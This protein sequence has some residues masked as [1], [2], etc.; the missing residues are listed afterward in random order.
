M[1]YCDG[2]YGMRRSFGRMEVLG[3]PG[4]RAHS[5]RSVA[6]RRSERVSGLV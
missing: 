1:C 6:L 5:V 4:L 3:D 2:D